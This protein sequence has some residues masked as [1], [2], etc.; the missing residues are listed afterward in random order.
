MAQVDY[1]L[2][3]DGIEGESSD[4]KHKGEIE[5]ASWSWSESQG[6]HAQ[7]LGG[8]T[9]GKVEARGLQF[10]SHCSKASAKFF[11]AC[12]VGEHFK[13]AVL[14]CRKAGTV[15]QEFFK[16]TMSEVLV[17]AYSIGGG[18]GGPLPVDNVTLT[19]SKMEIEYK[20]QTSKGEVGSP[21][22]A[23]YDFKQNKKV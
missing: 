21:T 3:M 18:S 7:I 14:L 12:A 15:Q 20:E 19:F 16:I 13:Q 23:G 17:T 1:F 9:S 10:T 11:L 5:V 22:K 2:K 4:S 8:M 6:S